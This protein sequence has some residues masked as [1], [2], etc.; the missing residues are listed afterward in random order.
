[1]FRALF[2]LFI[3]IPIVEIALLLQISDVIG[4]WSTLALVVITAFIGAKLVKQQG[5]NALGNVQQQMAQGQMPAQ[6]LF[7]GLC[8][9]IAGVLLLTPGVMTDALGFLLLTP[10]VRSR[11]AKNLMTQAQAKMTNSSQSSFYYSSHTQT[12]PNNPF[13]KVNNDNEQNSNTLDG[14]FK[15]KD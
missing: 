7:A 6:D 1:M 11:L 4:G 10:A 13:E 14:E 3:V 12:P 2:I 5:V 8:I 9:I 15:R